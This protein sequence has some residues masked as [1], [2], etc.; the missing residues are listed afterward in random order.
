MIDSDTKNV[1]SVWIGTSNKTLDEFNKYTEGM[2]DLD[3]QCPAFADFG[4][5]F[6]DSDF[7]V[8][9][10][11]INGEIVSIEILAEEIGTHS[12]KPQKKL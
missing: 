6:I 4:V 5:S 7:F 1:I 9:F 2:E 11:T 3:S 8:A 12:K 10:R